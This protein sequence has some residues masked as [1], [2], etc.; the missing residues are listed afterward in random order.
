MVLEG[1]YGAFND[2]ASVH[3]WGY[4][5][6]GDLPVFL[7][8][9]LVFGADLITENLEVGLLALQSEAAHNG[10]VGYNAIRVLFSIEGGDKDCVGATMVG[11]QS[12][13]ITATI[14]DGGSP[15]AVCVK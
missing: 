5:M 6:V 7:D 14:S 4:K 12:V 9:T 15:N 8:V 13:L 2:I 3:V 11:N 10:F 1:V